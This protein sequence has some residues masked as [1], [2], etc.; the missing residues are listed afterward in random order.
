MARSTTVRNLPASPVPHPS[1]PRRAVDDLLAA[2]GRS[3]AD[4]ALASTPADRYVAAHLAALRAGAAVLADRSRPS[5]R[6]TRVQSVWS[7][8]PRVAPELTEWSEFFAVT[9]RRRAALE[10]GLAVI[11]ARDADDLA[12]DAETFVMRVC[13]A[14]GVAHL[15]VVGFGPSAAGGWRHA[16]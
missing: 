12:R 5:G 11:A 13:E 3:L 8:L 1:P 14:V 2:A 10:S 15:Q 7:L 9:A 16:G 6:R 4:A